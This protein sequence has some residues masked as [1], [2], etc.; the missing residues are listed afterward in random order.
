MASVTGWT[1]SANICCGGL[2]PH[3]LCQNQLLVSPTDPLK[4]PP[5]LSFK[6]PVK[7][8][9]TSEFLSLFFNSQIKFVFC[10]RNEILNILTKLKDK[11]EP[12]LTQVPATVRNILAVTEVN[13]IKSGIF[14]LDNDIVALQH[15]VQPTCLSVHC[16]LDILTLV[17]LPCPL[18]RYLLKIL[19]L[20]I[21]IN[22]QLFYQNLI[23]YLDHCSV[24]NFIA[25]QSQLIVLLP[26]LSGNE[27]GLLCDL[28]KMTK[29]CNNVSLFIL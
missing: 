10:F 1:I 5:S 29:F 26:N 15:T 24:I 8:I 22:D 4:I 12:K 23:N 6:S 14:A 13:L 25:A 17:Y 28:M 21:V 9:A 18:T 11:P 27:I 3:T 7:S 16:S 19:S 20:L 2:L